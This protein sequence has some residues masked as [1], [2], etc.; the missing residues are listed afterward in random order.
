MSD[1]DFLS[2]DEEDGN[3]NIHA[4]VATAIDNN[5][6]EQK[7]ITNTEMN[8]I[9]QIETAD[10]SDSSHNSDSSD[11]EF[12]NDFEFGGL[13]VSFYSLFMFVCLFLCFVLFCFVCVLLLIHTSITHHPKSSGRRW[14]RNTI[15]FSALK[16]R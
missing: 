3:S 16:L 12:G 14:A 8:N 9:D 11:D 7:E 1:L 13:L 2:S 5:S 4:N 15:D 10:D 6:K